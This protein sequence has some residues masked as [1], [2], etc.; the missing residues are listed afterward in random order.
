MSRA[1]NT[2]NPFKDN[3]KI[4]NDRGIK[5]LY[6]LWRNYHYSQICG[7]CWDKPHSTKEEIYEV[8]KGMEIVFKELNTRGHVLNSKDRKIQRL[9]RAKQGRRK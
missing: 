6:H 1:L 3:L 5:E 4:I 8:E 9:N 2:I 7:C